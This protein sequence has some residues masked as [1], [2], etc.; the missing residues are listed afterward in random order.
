MTGCPP[1]PTENWPET[2][3]I[4]TCENPKARGP[5]RADRAVSRTGGAP[6]VQIHLKHGTVIDIHAQ[7]CLV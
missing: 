3:P 4:G 1:C 7:R 2:K 6:C 5:V